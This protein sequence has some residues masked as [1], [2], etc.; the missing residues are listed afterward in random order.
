MIGS[1]STQPNGSVT[2]EMRLDDDNPEGNTLLIEKA[3]LL[4]I[5]E[6]LLDVDAWNLQQN[7]CGSILTFRAERNRQEEER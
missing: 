7:G 4:S 6:N 5:G 3:T 2:S 1:G